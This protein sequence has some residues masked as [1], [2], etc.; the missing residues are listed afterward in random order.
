[1]SASESES[2][3]DFCFVLVFDFLFGVAAGLAIVGLA[4]AAAGLA[5]AVAGLFAVRLL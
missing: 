4:V 3:S 2:F 1:V 5:V